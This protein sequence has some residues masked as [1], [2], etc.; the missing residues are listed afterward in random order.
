MPLAQP[1]FP[2]MSKPLLPPFTPGRLLALG[3]LSLASLTVQAQSG[4]GIGTTAP[5]AS[6][7]LEIASSSKGA[8]LP[9]L[10]EA[11]RLAMGTGSVPAPAPGLIVYQT[12]G[13]QPGF[14]YASS[15]STWV[16]LSDQT[17][18][19]GQYIQNQTAAV[20]SAG[21]AIS[22]NALVGGRIGLGV[23][24]G[25]PYS[26]LANTTSN[27]VGSDSQGGNPGSLAWSAN[28]SGYVGM[29]FNGGTTANR[30][31]LAVKVAGTDPS[32]SILDLSAGAAQGSAGTAIMRVRANGR[33]GIGIGSPGYLLDV[34]GDMNTSGLFRVNGAPMMYKRGNNLYI[35]TGNYAPTAPTGSNN[36]MVGGGNG[37]N[38]TSGINNTTLGL[39]AGDALTE[40]SSN[41]LIGVQTGG[42]LTTGTDNV[43]IGHDPGRNSVTGSRNIG[44]GSTALIA[45][46]GTDNV[47]IG[48]G[49][50]NSVTTGSSNT[51][52]GRN[53]NV[54]SGTAQ[55]N[56]ATALGYNAKVNQDDAVVLGDAG[57]LATR[58]GIGTTAPTARLEVFQDLKVSAGTAPAAVSLGTALT[59]TQLVS[60]TDLGQSFTL[61]ATATVTGLT[62]EAETAQTATLTF[63]SGSGN[64]GSAVSTPQT[65]SLV[66]TGPTAITLTTPL[67]LGAGTY[68]FVLDNGTDLHNYTAS[69]Y[70]GGSRYVGSTAVPAEDLQFLLSY[71]SSGSATT[72]LY[73]AS[74][75][76]V[77]IGTSSPGTTLDVAGST[78]TVRLQGLAGTGTRV[79]T[80]AADGTLGT[81][82]TASLADNLGNHTATTNLNLGSNLL[83]GGGS[84]GL[85]VAADGSLA[86]GGLG[87]AR[88]L[89]S[90]SVFLGGAGNGTATGT[91]NYYFG[92]GAGANT[93]AATSNTYIGYQAGQSTTANSDNTAVGYQAGLAATGN[94]STLIGV[95]AGAGNGGTSNVAVGGAAGYLATGSNNTNIG[96]SAGF[97]GSHAGGDNVNVGYFTGLGNS[98][99]QNTFLG[100]RAG[101]DNTSGSSNVFVGSFAGR[102]NT[103]GS[104]NTIIGSG[105]N[106]G[107]ANPSLTYA[108]AIGAGALVT[109]SNSLVLGGTGPAAV[110]VGIGTAAPTATL[111][112]AGASSTVKLQGLG[113]TGTRVVTAAADGTLG[114]QT[115]ASVGDNLGTGVGTTDVQIPAANNYTYAAAKS[116]TIH[117]GA[118]DFVAESPNNTALST[119]NT[120]NSLYFVNTSS[121]LAVRAPLRLPEGAVITGIT[122]YLVDNTATADGTLSAHAFQPS[123]GTITSVGTATA[124][125]GSSATVATLTVPVVAAAATVANTNNLYYVRFTSSSNTGSTNLLL[126]G[127]RITYT[128]TKAD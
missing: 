55:R 73:A 106:T 52:V 19:N 12:D 23:G 8:L 109:Q 16:R 56:R 122:G 35:G 92:D 117:V 119:S 82:T 99:G 54:A 88:R 100:S 18:A 91:G 86:L 76:R 13:T 50:G 104:N 114:T 11:A 123:T 41:V 93:T 110:K 26:Q 22:G 95:L 102:F 62:L 125:S 84:T 27:I 103:N 108:A 32:A 7:A 94:A 34:A 61:S 105:A 87:L 1:F 128:V 79:V 85:G 60:G 6:A 101:N 81:T 5:D 98:G 31:G 75:G 80:A 90:T 124:S 107:A 17:T 72:T 36:V 68:T 14:W 40:G 20:Q 48:Q 45:A 89:S 96:Y 46:E 51:F 2:A 4:V 67:V 21:F 24:T 42:S 28:Q 15:A 78:S 121:G 58:V 69:A 116:Y 77:G 9:R 47:A 37:Y 38:L 120:G 39:L 118:A 49:S 115:I 43:F 111:D 127:V 3:L 44:I 64:G 71:T 70:A 10:T 53:T 57:N 126:Y 63:Y 74:S 25:T 83:T 112:V 97:T 33:V 65:I 59:A 113:G 29:F 30:N 66:G